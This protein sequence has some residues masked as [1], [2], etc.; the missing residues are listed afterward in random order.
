MSIVQKPGT[1]IEA[2]VHLWEQD[3][4]INAVRYRSIAVSVRVVSSRYLNLAA[5]FLHGSKEK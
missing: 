4:I 3:N 5:D 1:L 2:V